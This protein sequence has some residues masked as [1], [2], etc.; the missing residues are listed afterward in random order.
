MG[1]FTGPVV[2]VSIGGFKDVLM[3]VLMVVCRGVLKGF[4]AFMRLH[5]GTNKWVRVSFCFF[6]ETLLDNLSGL[7]VFQHQLHLFL[8]YDGSICFNPFVSSCVSKVSEE[9]GFAGL[10][11]GFEPYG[12]Q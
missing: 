3:G 8:Q 5:S 6:A 10:T 9:I 2:G 4:S 7:P 1:F 11:S 12:A